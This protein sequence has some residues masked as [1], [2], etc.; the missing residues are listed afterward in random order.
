MYL[1]STTIGKAYLGE[2]LVYSSAGGGSGEPSYVT[3]GLVLHLDGEDAT[4]AQWAARKGNV[5]FAMNNVSLDG[6][7][8]VVFNG[9]N[10][11]G[12]Y[13]NSL[14]LL[15]DSCTIEVVVYFDVTNN[16]SQMVFATNDRGG[17]AFSIYNGT[18]LICKQSTNGV[19]Y[20]ST[21]K[22]G[23]HTFSV[24][25][26][27][28]YRDKTNLS[29]AAQNQWNTKVGGCFLG[30]REIGNLQFNGTIYQIRI[31]NRLLSADE[32][33]ANQDID[34]NRYNIS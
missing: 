33:L 22:S 5:S 25:G 27:C 31:Y 1:G 29:T 9:S 4:T 16:S 14:G 30:C 28:A 26:T 8:G 13:P 19:T 32:I 2:D 24:N 34:I 21:V 15:F 6:N 3:N 20:Y 23:L 17:C 7:G 10:S 18:T 12:N 11:Y